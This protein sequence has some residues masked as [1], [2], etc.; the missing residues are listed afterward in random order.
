MSWQPIETAPKGSDA[1]LLWMPTYY[2]GK[3]GHEVGV[4]HPRIEQFV[5]LSAVPLRHPTHWMPLPSG[6]GEPP[7]EAEAAGAVEELR[8]LKA[9]LVEPR[10]HLRGAKQRGDS[11]DRVVMFRTMAEGI[12]VAIEAIDKRIAAL[13]SRA[14]GEAK[15]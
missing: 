10:D 3:G 12:E 7:R 15:T 13:A 2:R 9:E 1:V 5:S 14:A 8:K 11:L 6:P 4:W